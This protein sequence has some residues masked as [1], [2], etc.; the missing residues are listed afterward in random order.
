MG[1]RFPHVYYLSRNVAQDSLCDDPVQDLMVS[2]VLQLLGCQRGQLAALALTDQ[3]QITP[4]RLQVDGRAIVLVGQEAVRLTGRGHHRDPLIPG[5]QEPAYGL[6]NLIAAFGRWPRRIVGAGFL[7]VAIH[8]KRQQGE[9]SFRVQVYQG[10]D[11]G[12]GQAP[13]PAPRAL[14]V[15]ISMPFLIRKLRMCLEKPSG[16]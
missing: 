14:E 1:V 15:A 4:V 6:A 2:G 5:V 16:H 3:F 11:D 13:V 7:S 10:V 12:M 9:L 8:E